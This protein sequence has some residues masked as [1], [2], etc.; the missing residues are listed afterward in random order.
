M[1]K[2]LNNQP[3]TS[4]SAELELPPEFCSTNG[5]PV[6]RAT[7]KRERMVEILCEAVRQHMGEPVA[8]LHDDGHYTFKRKPTPYGSDHAGWQMDVFAAPI[9]PAVE[10]IICPKCGVDRGNVPCPGDLMNCPI[11][12][13]T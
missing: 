11:R 12:A 7:I 6:E 10:Q 9:P 3:S 8:I 13:Y 1:V 4:A 5:I 2:R